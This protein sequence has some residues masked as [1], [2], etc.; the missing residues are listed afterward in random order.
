MN[1]VKRWKLKGFIPGVE[2]ESKAV[3]QPVVVLA[4]DFDASL[5]R[6]STLG[7]KLYFAERELDRRIE[8]ADA[9]QLRLAAS[10]ELLEIWRTWLGPN[11]ENCD[12][13]GKKIWDRID[14]LK[15]VECDGGCFRTTDEAAALR[16]KG[17]DD[18]VK[19]LNPFVGACL[20]ISQSAE[21]LYDAGYRKLIDMSGAQLEQHP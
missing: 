8:L 11:R 6:E 14:S 9:L 5:A 21:A 19:V 13:G 15:P 20:T 12:E 10:E 17:I 4:E 3:F 16:K 7:E 2:G 1:E 18:L